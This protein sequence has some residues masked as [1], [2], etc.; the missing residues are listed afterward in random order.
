MGFAR[1]PNEDQ[2]FFIFIITYLDD[3]SVS[4]SPIGDSCISHAF[5]INSSVIN[6]S[7]RLVRQ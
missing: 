7:L 1:Q 5:I 6:L 3:L 4:D 2:T